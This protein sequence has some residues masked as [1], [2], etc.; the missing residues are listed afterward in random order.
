MF[1]PTTLDSF[2]PG[3]HVA[4]QR[5]KPVQHGVDLRR[6]RLRA[7][8]WI[9]LRAEDARYG[10]ESGSTPCQLQKLTTRNFH[11]GPTA[12]CWD[13]SDLWMKVCRHWGAVPSAMNTRLFAEL[14]LIGLIAS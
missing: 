5:F 9:G 2:V 8:R 7:S 13:D 11:R 1:L 14:C 12:K 10:R 6:C 4:L 3:R